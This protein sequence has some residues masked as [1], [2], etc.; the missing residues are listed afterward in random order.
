MNLLF[1]SRKGPKLTSAFC[2]RKGYPTAHSTFVLFRVQSFS[3]WW[4]KLKHHHLRCLNLC[5]LKWNQKEGKQKSH[6]YFNIVD[7]W[8]EADVHFG[9]VGA[10][11]AVPDFDVHVDLVSC[12]NFN[13][14]AAE[15][16]SKLSAW[17]WFVCLP[18]RVQSCSAGVGLKKL[19]IFCAENYNK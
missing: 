4:C 17:L 15:A 11:S 1:G 16:K 19:W 2:P 14:H 9:V 5:L 18:T 12:V 3:G 7:V 8:R 13:Q 10:V 6:L